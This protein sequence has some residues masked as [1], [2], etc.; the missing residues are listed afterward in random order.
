MGLSIGLHGPRPIIRL[1]CRPANHSS[2]MW[3]ITVISEYTIKQPIVITFHTTI[4]TEYSTQTPKAGSD[5]EM[6]KSY[7]LYSTVCDSASLL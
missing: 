2:V 1:H 5:W 4:I 6:Y 3:M 7:I